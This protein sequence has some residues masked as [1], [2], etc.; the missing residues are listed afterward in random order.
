M[1]MIEVLLFDS[2]CISLIL[3]NFFDDLYGGFFGTLLNLFYAR[4]YHQ[5]LIQGWKGRYTSIDTT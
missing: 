2:I 4:H 5:K 1:M 3:R